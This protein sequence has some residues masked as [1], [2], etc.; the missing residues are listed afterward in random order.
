MRRKAWIVY[1]LIGAVATLGFLF[2]P[3]PRAS[4]LFN[5]I[6]FSSPIMIVVAV[7]MWKPE[8]RL[9]WYLFALGQTL[10]ICGDV[11]AY[12]YHALLRHRSAVPGDQRRLLSER[13]SRASS[14]GCCC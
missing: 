14:P 6:G 10:F 8:Q 1:P 4:V 7:R 2:V 11:I 5:A 13:L 3:G 12:N 9:P